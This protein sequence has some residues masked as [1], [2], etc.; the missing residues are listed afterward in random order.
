MAAELEF[1]FGRLLVPNNTVI[2]QATNELR[3][4]FQLATEEIVPV[5]VTVLRSSQ[6]PQAR[7]YAAILLRRRVIKQWTKLSEQLQT[8]LKQ[9]VLEVL[10]SERENL[11]RQSTA[12]IIGGIAKHELGNGQWPEL[13]QFIEECMRE[14]QA[15]HYEIAVYVLSIVTETAG[16]ELRPHFPSLFQL[17]SKTLEEHKNPN[18]PYFT[19]R[20]ITQLVIF[21]GEDEIKFLRPL[22]PKIVNTIRIFLTIDEDKA[23]ECMDVFDELVE[24]EVSIVVP[25]IKS[26]VDFCLQI[27]MN[28]GLSDSSRVKALHFIGWLIRVKSKVI[29]RHKLLSAILTV[30]FAMMA[31]HGEED[32]NCEGC[33]D[34]TESLPEAEDSRPNAVAA[35]VLDVLA[36][37]M[38]P[39]KLFPPLMQLIEPALSHSNP[40]QRKAAIVS[41]AVLSEGC[42]DY[43]KNRHLETTLHIVCQALSDQNDVVRN[44][45]LFALGQFAEHLQPDISKFS[46]SILPL[47]FNYLGEIK[48]KCDAPGV[49]R[50]FYALETFCENLGEGIL[51]Y[52]PVLME[53]M[54]ETLTMSQ[55][56]RM[57]G[58]AISAIGAA[59]NASGREMLPYFSKV[60]EIVKEYICNPEFDG[61]QIQAQC[62]DTIG[63]LARVIGG[64]NFYPIAGEWISISL[65]LLKRTNDPDARR[66]VYGLFASLSTFMKQEMAGYLQ[67]ILK[68]MVET[69]QSTEGIVTHYNDNEDPPFLIDENI[70]DETGEDS[71]DDS[72]VGYSVENAYL[73]EKEDAC[74]AIGEIAENTNAVFLPY[75]DEII[76]EVFKLVQHPHTGIRKGSLTAM[77]QLCCTLYSVLNNNNEDKTFLNNVVNN[78]VSILTMTVDKDKEKTVVMVALSSLEKMLKDMKHDVLQHDV[79]NYE[80]ICSAIKNVLMFKT[81]CQDNDDDEI[82]GEE[83]ELAELDGSLLEHAGDVVPQL[84][85]A[86]PGPEFVAYFASILPWFLKQIFCLGCG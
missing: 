37:H 67:A 70:D 34:E 65:D 4:F 12:Q 24:S 10:V 33:E 76:S 1:I 6:S 68:F 47:L 73:D 11:V 26:L 81:H 43:I 16:E 8:L 64:E 83:Q 15:E 38:P 40:Y 23:C 32:G 79:E 77:C 71:D 85:A 29:I 52:L 51:P 39:E 82:E 36:L 14:T 84:A 48:G 80:Q 44:A 2:K 7:Q 30:I 3:A 21:L 46:S 31:T 13:F 55:S 54:I 27:A 72:V 86:V 49:T 45:A 22:I 78:Y 19:V 69:L 28:T 60:V 35:Q 74:N 66:C 61:A 57:K 63:M 20:A 17:F 59:A 62:L 56:E 50:T 42:A 25:H 53:R 75:M 58:L 41:L 9:T 5:L 18:I